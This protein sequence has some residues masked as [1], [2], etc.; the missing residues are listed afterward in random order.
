[1]PAKKTKDTVVESVAADSVVANSSSEPTSSE[2]TSASAKKTHIDKSP[3]REREKIDPE[4]GRKIVAELLKDKKPSATPTFIGMFG[5]AGSGKSH[6]LG[7]D[8]MAEIPLDQSD[9]VIISSN[10]Y[11]TKLPSAKKSLTDCAGEYAKLKELPAETDAIFVNCLQ[12]QIKNSHMAW[13]L[14]FKDLYNKAKDQKINIFYDFSGMN[15]NMFKWM[16]ADIKTAGYKTIV[17]YPIADSDKIYKRLLSTGAKTGILSSKSYVDKIIDDSQRSISEIADSVDELYI[18]DNNDKPVKVLEMK[19]ENGK[20]NT[21]CNI[22]EAFLG[23]R[24]ADFKKFVENVC[25]KKTGGAP[26]A[27]TVTS[28]DEKLLN[29]TPLSMKFIGSSEE[30]ADPRANAVDDS[31]NSESVSADASSEVSGGCPE[32]GGMKKWTLIVATLCLVVILLMIDTVAANLNVSR[33]TVIAVTT[34]LGMA[35]ILLAK[36]W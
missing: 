32:C 24:S 8:L 17:I 26:A 14:I 30:S 22:N 34:M 28:A 2:T 4:V 1:M 36:L 29:T 11:I 3:S 25:K 21:K 9:G 27:I 12:S 7:T 13:H 5:P 35:I 10:Y 23:K 18:Y 15:M 31:S 33:T 20:L 16:L 19:K 6:I